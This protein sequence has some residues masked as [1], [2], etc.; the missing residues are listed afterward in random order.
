MLKAEH[1]SKKFAIPG[2]KEDVLAAV[3]DV[4][5]LVR[6]NETTVIVGE[7]GSGKSTLAKMLSFILKPDSG[8]VLLDGEEIT[9]CKKNV[10]RKRRG[11]VQLVMQNA[12]SSL[13]PHQTVRQILEEPQ[14]LLLG[15]SKEEQEANIKRLLFQVQL[16]EDVLG[17][18]PKEF[19]GGQQKRICIARA[20]A[21][22]PRHIIFDES[23]SGLDVTLKKQI[24]T[25]LKDLQKT[26]GLS[27]L[28]ISHDLDTAFFM[29]DVIHIMKDGRII[30]TVKKPEGFS[31]LKDPYS[32]ELVKAAL[33]KRAALQTYISNQGVIV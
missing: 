16:P 10:L 28:I 11:D 8:K 18:R 25:L 30:E 29:A 22:N 33:F 4:S 3:Q 5:L 7:S 24:L 12:V 23:F 21:T 14:R 19:S 6:D 32:Q 31:D 9:N 17:R 20:L 15:L 1:F 27:Y 26:D 2:G 13:D